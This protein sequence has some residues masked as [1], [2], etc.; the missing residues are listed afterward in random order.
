MDDLLLPVIQKMN[1]RS[2]VRTLLLHLVKGCC[3]NVGLHSLSQQGALNKQGNLGAFFDVP[4]GVG[5][6]RKRQAYSSKRLQQVVSDFRKKQRAEGAQSQ[7]DTPES[8][9]EEEDESS[10]PKKKR[11]AGE[12]S[13][14][15]ASKK[16]SE[17]TRGSGRGRGR[18]RGR[19]GKTTRGKKAGKGKSREESDASED[20]FQ[21]GSTPAV[22]AIPDQPL[23][24]ELRPRPKPRM[25]RRPVVEHND[26][27]SD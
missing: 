1:K 20:E 22:E 10:R 26:D 6:P 11:K 16:K 21:E 5:A 19:G 4:V 3:S 25:R 24:V 23:A 14:A 8:D 12:A 9:T 27:A 18:G 7:G 15:S 13:S 17:T 2:Q